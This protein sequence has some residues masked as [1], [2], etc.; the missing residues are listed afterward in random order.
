M[1]QIMLTCW[2]N[3]RSI[4]TA[5][6]PIRLLINRENVDSWVRSSKGTEE[7]SLCPVALSLS[8]PPPLASRAPFSTVLSPHWHLSSPFPEHKQ[9]AKNFALYW[10]FTEQEGDCLLK[11]VSRLLVRQQNWGS[12]SSPT[13]APGS[14]FYHNGHVISRKLMTSLSLLRKPWQPHLKE[15]SPPC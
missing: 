14:G 4:P 2:T 1:G 11:G 8:D 15:S 6:S 10:F 3:S 9:S 13:S 7:T 5:T 12:L